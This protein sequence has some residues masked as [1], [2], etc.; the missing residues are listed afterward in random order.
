M[1]PILAT[2]SCELLQALPRAQ[3]GKG[4]SV[5][6]M[7]RPLPEMAAST[8]LT[9][10]L[11]AVT[12]HPWLKSSAR[13][14][15]MKAIQNHTKFIR[16]KILVL[17]STFNHMIMVT[18]RTPLTMPT[19][20]TRGD[21]I[22]DT[23]PGKSPN[24]SQISNEAMKV[25]KI[26]DQEKAK[27][28][29]T[30]FQRVK[31]KSVIAPTDQKPVLWNCWREGKLVSGM[32]SGSPAMRAYAAPRTVSC[33]LSPKDLFQC[34][35][36]ILSTKP[37]SVFRRLRGGALPGQPS[38]SSLALE[39]PSCPPSEG[40]EE[41][42]MRSNLVWE[43]NIVEDRLGRSTLTGSSGVFGGCQGDRCKWN[44]AKIVPGKTKHAT[45]SRKRARLGWEI[46][47]QVSSF[48]GAPTATW[49]CFFLP[50]TC[51]LVTCWFRRMSNQRSCA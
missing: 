16:E 35:R 44:K 37:Y 9:S 41:P 7:A 6:V 22:S 29:P 33:A 13:S 25:P 30:D 18:K 28:S 36:N 23:P 50:R 10:E 8:E 38:T 1:A 42:V 46:R 3:S 19:Q 4:R 32:M 2:I 15:S 5:A 20:K 11:L 14:G 40:T 17:S 34:F 26:P 21:E 45:G 49:S 47:P 48:T 12:P 24:I 39:S 51:L 31:M 27:V 43:V